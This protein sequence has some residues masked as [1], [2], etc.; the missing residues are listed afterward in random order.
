[1][2]TPPKAYWIAHVTVTDAARYKGYQSLAPAAFAKFG[3]RFLAQGS[4]TVT[5]EG[6]AWERN[7][8]IEFKDRDTALACYHSDE[9]RQARAKRSGACLANIMITDGVASA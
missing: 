8:V 3:A 4:E 7:V 9:Y 6:E 5:L 2:L 1:M